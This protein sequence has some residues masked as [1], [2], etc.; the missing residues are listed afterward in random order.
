MVCIYCA[1]STQVSNS[2]LQKRANQVWRRRQCTQCGSNF[3]THEI[4]DYGSTIAVEYSPKKLVP[5]SRDLLFI[6]IFDSC[7]HRKSALA[8]ASALTLTIIGKLT[9]LVEDGL[10]DRDAIVTVATTVLE[11]FDIVAATM[12]AAY[13]PMAKS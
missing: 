10:L 12:Y 9:D 3:T 8:D 4:A 11:R 6:S 2:R 5:F 13:H 7:K 1:S